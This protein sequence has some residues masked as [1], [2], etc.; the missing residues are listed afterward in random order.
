MSRAGGGQSPRVVAGRLRPLPVQCVAGDAARQGA[1]ATG[2]GRLSPA[3][4]AR[5][6]LSCLH[7]ALSPASTWHSLLPPLGTASCL[8]VALSPASAWHSP[9]PPRRTK[10]HS[11][12]TFE[13]DAAV[14][15]PHGMPAS[16]AKAGRASVKC[17]PG[18]RPTRCAAEH[19][20]TL[21][22]HDPVHAPQKIIS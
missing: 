6:T 22:V 2:Q 21:C 18:L 14:E 7:V 15:W 9:K 10:Q 13:V 8:Y 20:M 1:L 5:G 12:T 16:W 4:G 17:L 11:F 3:L 19:V